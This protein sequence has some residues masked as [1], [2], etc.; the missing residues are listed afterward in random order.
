MKNYQLKIRKISGFTLVEMLISMAIFMGFTGV[1]I[2]SYS[3]I[4]RSQHEANEY[5]ELYVQARQIFETLIQELRDGMLDYDKTVKGGLQGNKT[6]YL[7]SKDGFVKTD[8]L[9]QK[10]DDQG[11]GGVVSL[12]KRFLNPDQQPGLQDGN[13]GPVDELI[14]NNPEVV[15]VSKFRIYYSPSIDPYDPKYVNYDKNQ[16]HPRVTVY[17]EFEKELLS[18]KKYIMDL[19]TTVSSRIYSQVY[20]T[21]YI[22]TN[23]K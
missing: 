1:L 11:G 6:V 17:A 3:T 13:Y 9:Y 12:Q 20:P 7:I 8:V 19:Q 23:I 4:V 16:F 5:R 18:G 10:I 14:L 15:K 22:Y 2:G 21:E